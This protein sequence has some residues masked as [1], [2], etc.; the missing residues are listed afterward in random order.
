MKK[1][2][3]NKIE[4]ILIEKIQEQNKT[5]KWIINI[6]ML[7]GSISFF[8]VG[9]SSYFNFNIFP[10]L[11]SREIIFF[12]QGI[13]M[14]FYGISGLFFS[15]NQIFIL[16]WKIGEGYNEFNKNKNNIKIYR[17]GFPGKNQEIEL[18][19]KI[20]QIEKIKLEIKTELFNTKQKI[21]LCIKD[22]PDLPILQ[23]SNPLKIHEIEK[24][25]SKIASF[26]N[27]PIKNS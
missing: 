25:A 9:L 7:L 16:Y 3:K 8:T 4:N 6:I 10:I 13:I 18:N 2:I 26:I 1:I 5:T 15:I 21:Y 11:D 19:Y 17:K 12:P 14:S 23:T 27:V 22:R 20:N 24:K